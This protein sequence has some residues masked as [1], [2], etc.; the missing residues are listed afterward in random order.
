MLGQL[1]GHFAYLGSR[2]GRVAGA[3]GSGGANED[4]VGEY[5]TLLEQEM[6]DFVLYEIPWITN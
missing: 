1:Q 5:Q 2:F 6:F 3:K 4:F